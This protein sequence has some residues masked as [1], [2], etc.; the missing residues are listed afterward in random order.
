MAKNHSP[1]DWATTR[2][3]LAATI[4]NAEARSVGI[5]LCDAMLDEGPTRIAAIADALMSS[6]RSI[7]HNGACALAE[8][9]PDLP[10][11]YEQVL[12]IWNSV[13]ALGRT[14]IAWEADA[15]NRGTT[16]E[17]NIHLRTL[18]MTDCAVQVR[19]D[20][21]FVAA[22]CNLT[23]LAPLLKQLAESDSDRL[24]RSAANE[25]HDLLTQGYRVT[26]KL[27]P[28]HDTYR[29]VRLTSRNLRGHGRS[30]SSIKR[31]VWDRLGPERVIAE[32]DRC[33]EDLTQP[34]WEGCTD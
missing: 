8:V 29:L 3:G 11:P 24:V 26:P 22:R 31:E 21:V 33:D 27:A 18:A 19:R 7:A 28:H 17:Q 34:S 2:D 23:E 10:N 13:P 12:S 20:S 30:Y 9:L 5:A 32:L 4:K 14:R 16:R 1:R 6:S 15:I 25:S